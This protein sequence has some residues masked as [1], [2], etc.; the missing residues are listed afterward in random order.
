[1]RRKV[2]TNNTE[3]EALKQTVRGLRDVVQEQDAL[4][5][6]FSYQCRLLGARLDSLLRVQEQEEDAVAQERASARGRE[7]A[8][9]LRCIQLGQQVCCWGRR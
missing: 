6:A 4:I 8:L 5:A 2:E 7:D 1:M 9:K 3:L